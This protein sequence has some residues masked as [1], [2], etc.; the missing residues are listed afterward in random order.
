MIVIPAIDLYR[1][2]VVRLLQGSYDA[3]TYYDATPIQ[4]AERYASEGTSLLHVVDL[5]G[6][7]SE[8]RNNRRLVSRMCE[9]PNLEIQTGG[10]V[11]TEDDVRSYLDSGVSRVVI[12]SLAVNQPER[13]LKWMRQFGGQRFTLAMDV[14]IDEDEVP[15]VATHGW[16]KQS[17]T[18]LWDALGYFGDDLV[19]VLC[20]DIARDG[21]L[22]GPN[23]ALYRE[24]TLRFPNIQLQASGGVRH[25][26]D[27]TELE[28]LGV[29]GVITGKALLEQKLR[30]EEIRPFLRNA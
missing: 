9:L 15:R 20:T 27:I 4:L 29:A 25:I 30:F 7:K 21:A 19:H 23:A 16:Q 10:G 26:Q 28:D 2:R 12:G 22:M 1:G 5:D 18:S 6:A 13:V 11:R 8:G 14:R 17:S 24:C 3:V